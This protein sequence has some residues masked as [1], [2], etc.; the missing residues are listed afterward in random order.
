MQIRHHVG[1]KLV[2]VMLNHRRELRNDLFLNVVWRDYSNFMS[3]NILELILLKPDVLKELGK[4]QTESE[5][6]S[7]SALSF[8]LSISSI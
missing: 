4:S 7:Y 6:V 8:E 1:E 2:T 5:G 3:L